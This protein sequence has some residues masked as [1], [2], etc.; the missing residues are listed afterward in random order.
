MT[1]VD[2]ASKFDFIRSLGA[3]HV[4]DDTLGAFTKRGQTF[5]AILDG[6]A[7]R[8][9]FAYER[10]LKPC[11]KRFVVGGSVATM[12]QGLQLGPWIRR[13]TG[14]TIDFLVVRPN[15]KDMLHITELYEAGV[16]VSVIDRRYS[17]REVPEALQYL[18]EGRVRGK[19]VITFETQ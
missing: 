3:E 6:I 19:V 5:D 16:I 10:A 12:F 9:V 14:K 1:G 18:G 17:L 7:C 4:I 11:G 13:T 2:H 8:S 15:A